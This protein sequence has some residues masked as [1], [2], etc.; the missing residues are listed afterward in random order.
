MAKNTCRIP[1]VLD[2][3]FARQ[4]NTYSAI[5]ANLR[6]LYESETKDK[7]NSIE[8]YT[9]KL[10]PFKNKMMQEDK[11]KLQGILNCS[12]QDILST[13]YRLLKKDFTNNGEI[14]ELVNFVYMKFTEIVNGHI[15]DSNSETYK[16][17]AEQKRLGKHISR[18]E[19]IKHI[20]FDNIHANL[21]AEI[22][23]SYYTPARKSTYMNNLLGK[24]I[25]GGH[26]DT[27][28]WLAKDEIA[29][30]EGIKYGKKMQ[31]V[32]DFKNDETL[33]ADY[34]VEDNIKDGWMRE[35][36]KENPYK[37][38]GQEVRAYLGRQI[39]FKTRQEKRRVTDK[40]TG[41]KKIVYQD[42]RM[43]TK[44]GF[45]KLQN[46]VQLHKALQTMLVGCRDQQHMVEIIGRAAKTDVNMKHIYQDLVADSQLRDAFYRDFHKTNCKYSKIYT[47]FSNGLRKLHHSIIRSNS[48]KLS[49]YHYSN[50]ITKESNLAN[51][52]FD[53]AE[54]EIIV[55]GDKW[56]ILSGFI[57]DKISGNSLD[58][59]S[60]NINYDATKDSAKVAAARQY[61][62]VKDVID[63]INSALALGMTDR[64][65][66]DL[67]KNKV[68]LKSF[69]LDAKML[70]S[71]KRIKAGMAVDKMT[72]MFKDRITAMIATANEADSTSSKSVRIGDS[73]YFTDIVTCKLANTIDYVR[74]FAN[75]ARYYLS[76][77]SAKE[78]QEGLEKVVKDIKAW[79]MDKYGCS[80]EYY[81]TKGDQIIFYNKWI[82]SLY[83]TNVES[84]TDPDSFIYNFTY[85]RAMLFDNIAAEDFSAEFDLRTFIANYFSLSFDADRGY[86]RFPLFT[87]GDSLALKMI[88]APKMGYNRL[89]NEFAAVARQEIA[90]MKVEANVAQTLED[91]DFNKGKI[92][93]L[94]DKEKEVTDT[95]T[96]EKTKVIDELSGNF[97]Y[98]T[99][100]NNHKAELKEALDNGTFTEKC[101]EILKEELFNEY[102]NDFL[103]EVKTLDTFAVS[104]DGMTFKELS[105]FY[106]LT[107]SSMEANDSANGLLMYYLNTKLA[108]ALQYQFLGANPASYGL[109][110]AMQKR[111][112]AYNAP[113]NAMDIHARDFNGNLYIQVDAEGNPI[114]E[115]AIYFNDMKKSAL[116]TDPDF[117]KA[118][119]DRWG[120]NDP[121]YKMYL[122]NDATDG[123]GF[124]TIESYRRVM[125][126]AHQWS[127][128][129]ENAYN[130]L[131]ELR[132]AAWQRAADELGLNMNNAEDLVK[133]KLNA[134][135]TVEEID[136]LNNLN[137]VFQPIKPHTSTVE[138]VPADLNN[139]NSDVLLIPV[140][141]KYAEALIIPEMFP[142]GSFRKHLGVQMEAN[143][144][145]L[146][147]SQ[148]CVKVGEFGAADL[149]NST[150]ES[151]AEDFGKGYVHN[152]D[153]ADYTIQ[154]NVPEHINASQ[155]FGTQLRKH[156]FDAIGLTSPYRF[157]DVESVNIHGTP[158]GFNS[159][160]GGRN[161]LKFYNALICENMNSD[162]IDLTR[163]IS[164]VNRLSD[165]L[166][167][168]KG[169][170]SNSTI[171]D[172]MRFSLDNDGNFS[173]P[174]SEPSG[175]YDIESI[176]TSIFKREVNK[177]H[178]N[179]GS[180]VQ[181]SDF[182]INGFNSDLHVHTEVGPDGKTNITYI[183]CA[184]A[185]DL[186]WTDSEGNK[187][188]LK[189]S[190]YC[191][192]DGTLRSAED[193]SRRAE[194]GELTKIEQDYP[195][196]LDLVAYRIPTE[197]EYSI[198][199]LK[200]KRFYPKIMGAAIMVPS[201]YT[202]VAGFDFDIDKLY[203]FRKEFKQANKLS[204][205]DINKVWN[206][207]YGIKIEEDGIDTSKATDIYHKLI[208][209]RDKAIDAY[210]AA[211]EASGGN[212]L[213]DAKGGKG[214]PALKAALQSEESEEVNVSEH[215]WNRKLHSFWEEA[216]LQEELGM[217]A[218]EYFGQFL[219]NNKAKYVTFDNY[220]YSKDVAEN[221]VVAR[222]NELIK[223]IQ[224]RL[225]DPA[226]FDAR[227]TPGGFTNAKRDANVLKAALFTDDFA[228]VEEAEHFADTAT[229]EDLE[230]LDKNKDVTNVLTT[231]DYNA[232]NRVASKVIGIMANHNTNAVY[233][234][235]MNRLALSEPIKI[236]GEVLQDLNSS[237]TGRDYML[238]LAE[239]LASSVDA[240]KT[241]VLNFL[242]INSYTANT[243]ALLARLGLSTEEIGLFLNQ[244]IIR[245]VCEFAS[246]SGNN[247]V[248]TAINK[249]AKK[250]KLDMK[251]EYSG[252]LI[253]KTDLYSSLK[254][255]N[256]DSNKRQEN[257]LK[258]FKAISSQAQALSD[259]IGKTKYT[260]ANSI[261]NS[262]GGLIALVYDNKAA[263][264]K[265]TLI[266]KHLVMDFGN[267]DDQTLNE[268]AKELSSPIRSKEDISLESMQTSEY[269]TFLDGTPL[270]FEQMV[271]D[272]VSAYIK[273]ICKYFPYTTTQ[274]QRIYDAVYNNVVFGTMDK[275]IVDAINHQLPVFILN[276]RIDSPFNPDLETV[277][278]GRNKTYYTVDFP[279][280]L[281]EFLTDRESLKNADNKESEFAALKEKYSF[282][283][284]T[285]LEGILDNELLDNLIV[286]EYSVQTDDYLSDDGIRFNIGIENNSQF[287]KDI[288]D[289]LTSAW[290]DL[291]SDRKKSVLNPQTSLAH[292]L[293][294][295]NF[296]IRGYEVG[297][298]AFSNITPLSVKE[299]L[300][301]TP[302]MTYNMF[303]NGLN[304]GDISSINMGMFLPLFYANN[305]GNN[306]LVKNVFMTIGEDSF[307]GDGI[308]DGKVTSEL[309]QPTIIEFDGGE[310]Q[311]YSQLSLPA[312]KRNKSDGSR[313]I[314]SAFKVTERSG[315]T[316]LF[317]L[318][319]NTYTGGFDFANPQYNVRPLGAKNKYIEIPVKGIKGTVAD[320]SLSDLAFMNENTGESN[321][322]A[323][324]NSTTFSNDPYIE[325]STDEVWNY[326]E[327]VQQ[328]EADN[329]AER[330]KENKKN[331]NWCN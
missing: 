296:F 36:D 230:K 175:A 10:I 9:T 11:Q 259:F 301:V 70:A 292:S 311:D 91:G 87:T 254:D 299:T 8:E 323:G 293:F 322:E 119:A 208:A 213:L 235:A 130:R 329:L 326:S 140:E 58:K 182:G 161:F 287:D 82:D 75:D 61:T 276:T 211:E 114:P 313:A 108:Y 272:A 40:T 201:Q 190:D 256:L 128:A 20:G 303:Y 227:Y 214:L 236:F 266:N 129:Q 237:N 232:R 217:S 32:V 48:R 234:K 115:K 134:M 104:D 242:N 205:T 248:T 23:F 225:T 152:I 132:Q 327:A 102:K 289:G 131:Q 252:S 238:T 21:V 66:E 86:A 81:T 224:S 195:G 39:M 37:T 59:I 49:F 178:I 143:G 319:P 100:L 196:I 149:R 150:A 76:L 111:Y 312:S 184:M 89:M 1:S 25:E 94:A 116:D 124:R 160:N 69:L 26:I 138:K 262:I 27:F 305:I 117:M 126:M 158:R 244:P 188:P 286:D 220:D 112:K 162:L 7:I 22:N 221:S 14:R 209:A 18:Q 47:T 88:T 174:I 4:C 169:N 251:G 57:T 278:D 99:C 24:M 35:M 206:D 300:M 29:Q 315:R 54:G 125:G 43:K 95:E 123:Q 93:P 62:E 156:V 120:E 277:G 146:A 246:N 78:S 135:F 15:S 181:V 121:R 55:S 60:I 80:S 41:E 288:K 6:G 260:A 222:N 229:K 92:T 223:C 28:F 281:R 85:D 153:Y 186:S 317:V 187:I 325:E 270:A 263:N 302:Y 219:S 284:D 109:S 165:M 65:I 275:E 133:A 101:V 71:D 164:D 200:V 250:Y 12:K 255:T 137:T 294:M 304:D 258:A 19:I 151:F 177:Q 320:Y 241:P 321:F 194:D 155:L 170:D 324:D 52:I 180:C 331:N 291:L 167:K 98:L 179:G 67:I 212:T 298:N 163:K 2:E 84:L 207:I 106:A 127:A 264:E 74:S 265:E 307:K 172:V 192:A 34:H 31:Y 215:P 113:G 17:L 64:N 290:E 239:L 53:D 233:S 56:N 330:A 285:S 50:S 176:F 145:D 257:V 154:T 202:T 283:Q 103:D 268:E 107:P 185:F 247:S 218:S 210:I 297:N 199:N 183:D 308:P 157:G 5:I 68:F 316:R 16:W 73:T 46:P 189:F 79:V 63:T 193:P 249:I 141:H 105:N 203:Y 197:R 147:A 273:K 136:E 280:Q 166:T 144:I 77:D 243:A 309:G 310:K 271:H 328:Q 159:D 122:D 42:I 45:T 228:T 274:Y 51:T 295:Y 231:C 33:E 216:G 90:R 269:K 139:P 110:T 44:N 96:N 306:K 191:L 198:L 279:R 168:L 261:D 83:N 38:I 30:R 13:T 171:E 97:I 240:V 204:Q 314:V 245:E 173:N 72:Y 118:L 148:Q 253:N 282:L 267:F 318:M 3:Q 142:V 226:T